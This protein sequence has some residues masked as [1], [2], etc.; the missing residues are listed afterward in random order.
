MPVL[1]DGGGESGNGGVGIGGR[2]G[3]SEYVGNVEGIGKMI[4]AFL[5]EA[6]AFRSSSGG[7]GSGNGGG[8][9]SGGYIGSCF[10]S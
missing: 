5:I 9:G 8:G 2:C 4:A 6:D 1:D 3:N 10:S 7:G